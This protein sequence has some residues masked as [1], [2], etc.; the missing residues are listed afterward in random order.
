[1][2]YPMAIPV[3][4]PDIA[5]DCAWLTHP[6]TALGDD[7]ICLRIVRILLYIGMCLV[8]QHLLVR[9]V[10]FRESRVWRWRW[11]THL[12]LYSASSGL[13][14]TTNG[15]DTLL[16]PSPSPA[17]QAVSS[18]AVAVEYTHLAVFP[19]FHVDSGDKGTGYT[20]VA[21]TVA[22]VSW[23]EIHSTYFG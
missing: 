15:L 8:S 19:I 13:A 12:W 3:H 14:G 2:A 1:M 9:H 18:F 21:L 22:R 7:L 16:I 11:N 10:M 5:F 6:L 23:G 20:A 4:A 17:Y